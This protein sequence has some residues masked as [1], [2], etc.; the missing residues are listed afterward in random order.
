MQA[1]EEQVSRL[2]AVLEEHV[3]NSQ[4]HL[5]YVKGVIIDAIKERQ[6]LRAVPARLAPIQDIPFQCP[7]CGQQYQASGLGV[8]GK[9][10]V[11][12]LCVH[13]GI[14]FDVTAG[15]TRRV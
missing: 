3:R 4:S 10:Q 15:G 9:G 14:K 12:L 11:T 5:N 13:C 6:V 2:E 7:G 1:L 8:V